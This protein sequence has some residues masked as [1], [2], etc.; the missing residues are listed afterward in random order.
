MASDIKSLALVAGIAALACTGL[1]SKGLAEGQLAG[2]FA[3]SW[4]LCAAATFAVE[5]ETRIPKSLLTAISIAESGRRDDLN[6]TN[7]AW[8]WTV[9]SGT[10]QW[11][12][13]SKA[14][15]VAQVKSMIL[16]GKR[17]IDVGCMQVNLYFHGDAFGSL[18]AAFDPLSNVSYAASFLKRLRTS[19][20]DWLTAAGNY[21]SAT[22]DYH[23]RYKR[24]IAEIWSAQR[25]FYA[26][27]AG[28][29]YDRAGL[30]FVG[31]EVPPID[32]ARTTELNGAFKRRQT[33]EVE[34]FTKTQVASLPQD[35]AQGAIDG[36]DWRTAYLTQS[37]QSNN[38]ALQAQANR[39]RKAADRKKLVE[40]MTKKHENISAEMRSSDLDRWR[41][42]YSHAL[43]GPS[44]LQILSSGTQ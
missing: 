19:T 28:K 36:S 12:L 10:E 44:V 9:T 24:K 35:S 4:D 17:N 41:Q 23:R 42:R 2:E 27:N 5:R 33:A 39:V 20:E 6:K 30:L 22:P 37:G 7:V 1:P 8:P 40:N 13:D 11:Y 31:S 25:R 32:Q 26:N 16:D 3:E 34:Q 43:N 21:H 29:S 15:A 14:A 18:D 38:Y